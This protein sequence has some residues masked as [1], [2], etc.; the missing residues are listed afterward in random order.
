MSEK[1]RMAAIVLVL[2]LVG[3]A[4]WYLQFLSFPEKDTPQQVSSTPEP[5][6]NPVKSSVKQSESPAQTDT[7]V[8]PEDELTTAV[9]A[10]RDSKPRERGGRGKISGTISVTDGG[11]IP[12]DLAL[13]LFYIPDEARYDG[14]I[15]IVHSEFEA[16]GK[17]EYEFADL[18]LGQFY[19]FASSATHTGST[20]ANLIDSRPDSQRNVTL[21]PASFISGT[22]VN[23]AG[24]AITDAH[25]FVAGYLSNGNDIKANVYRSRCSEVPTDENGVFH[26]NNL[27]VR[28][29]QYR[30][31]AM[32]PGYAPTITE[33]LPT[34]STG[35]QIILGDGGSVAG[36]L[37]NQDTMEP[38]AGIPVTFA[39]EYAMSTE[40]K[41]TDDDGAFHFAGLSTG[42]YRF[43]VTDEDLVVTPD[44][45][46]LELNPGQTIEDIIVHVRLGGVVTGRIYDKD[47]N[48]GI[49]GAEI[50]AY[51]RRVEGTKRKLAT[52]DATG[53]YEIKGL[54]EGEYEIQYQNVKGY[55]RNRQYDARKDV[56]A[57][58]GQRMT[59]VDFPMSKGIA[60][61]GRVIDTDGNAMDG[62]RISGQVTRGN[63]YDSTNVDANGRF[64][65]YGFEEGF[66]V[67]VAAT[68]TGFGHESETLSL[69]DQPITGVEFVLKDEAKITG[70]VVDEIG[71][72]IRGVHIYAIIGNN[73]DLRDDATSGANGEITLDGL[74]DG[75]YQIRSH[76]SE[77][78]FS[79]SDP[80][81]ETITLTAGEHLDGLRL[82]VK[83]FDENTMTIA[84]RVTDDLGDPV[85]GVFLY[86]YGG[87][88]NQIQGTTKTDGTYVMP[89]AKK[90]SYRVSISSTSPGSNYVRT[91]YQFEAGDLAADF[92]LNRVGSVSG[93]VVDASHQPITDFS[94]M[95]IQRQYR[96]QLDRDLKR[97]H[98]DEGRFEIAGAHPG[99][100]N[101]MVFRAEG[102][103]D[104]ISPIH[105]ARPGETVRDVI[106]QMQA[107]SKLTGIVVDSGGNPVRNASI[108]KGEVPRNEYEQQRNRIATT[109]ADGRFELAGLQNGVFVIS[110]FKVGKAP[111]SA[112]ANV[113]GRLTEVELVLGDGGTL[114]GRVTVEGKPS[115]DTRISG[116]VQFGDGSNGQP[117][118]LQRQTDSDGNFEITGIPEGSGS[119]T[120]YLRNGNNQRRRTN[121]FEVRSD[122]VT[123]L[124]FDFP[125]ATSSIEGYLFV[126]ET[127]TTAGRVSLNVTN[128]GSQESQYKEVASDGYFLFESLPAGTVRMSGR[129]NED[130]TD[131]VQNVELGDNE[132]LRIDFQLYGGTAVT[133]TVNNIPHGV[134][135]TA[136][137][138]FGTHNF[139]GQMAMKDL[140]ALFDQP[141]EVASVNDGKAEFKKLTNGTYTIAVVSFNPEDMG[142]EK[143]IDIASTTVTIQ[144]QEEIQVEVSF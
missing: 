134:S 135:N 108:Y 67:R 112:T 79:T 119:L 104:S 56:M 124:N 26:M 102:F 85:A 100:E 4:L 93:R 68:K 14:A 114:A 11:T 70:T 44:T 87:N 49:P 76:P 46:K 21:Y 24:E 144:D 115:A 75:E 78:S 6:S 105:V 12:P 136:A 109:N 89:N 74:A 9:M 121:Q 32:A 58:L 101:E 47:T 141:A 62:V 37:V 142:P 69:T 20:S 22:V 27:Q 73:Y 126:S 17:A 23:T 51:G 140:E 8:E 61:S 34:G 60:I 113:G 28:T 130:R 63:G 77:N 55:S 41:I 15:D 57:K 50:S 99:V 40:E 81:L 116:N 65:L 1:A 48:Q 25:V 117:F 98:D 131:S 72:P 2:V 107:E 91:N 36:R 110:A 39:T 54:Y 38:A 139:Q 123:N 96:P 31:I 118:S 7:Q 19:I 95:V 92:V 42:S 86:A 5:A 97:F 71:N 13:T 111:T 43:N 106:V 90:G 29:P 133:C 94:A 143:L 84:G 82:V 83:G 103:A 45:T 127:E 53:Q 3:A 10:S 30:L 52:A 138:I 33:L 80:V 64:S 132:K 16:R 120:A 128:G 125:L 88:S 35:V 18:P 129:S 137:A 66:T 122:M 59:N